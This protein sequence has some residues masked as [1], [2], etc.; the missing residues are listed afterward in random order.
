MLTPERP[1]LR[2][3]GGK[4]RL[5]PWIISHMPAHRIYVE[6]FG[7]GASVLLRKN[8]VFSEIYNDLDGEIVNVFRVMRTRS[9]ELKD[10][11]LLTPWARSE[12]ELSFEPTDDPLESA[13]RVI[14][15]SFM[16]F[17]SDSVTGQ[18]QSGFRRQSHNSGRA[19]EKDWINYLDA[20]DSFVWRLRGVV[21]ENQ[22]AFEVMPIH[23]SSET[24]YFVDPPYVHSTRG[25]SNSYRHEYSE[26]DHEKLCSLLR[27]L[28]GM[29][30]L[31]G[32]EN[33]IYDKLGWAAIK[34]EAFADQAQ[35]RTEVLWLNPAAVQ[36]QAQ[37]SLFAEVTR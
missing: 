37:Q 9:W 33:P 32:Y 6:P 2:Y 4:W 11:L 31:C 23:D 12:Y 19:P 18:R 27:E 29:V 36:A 1:V 24:L 7:G 14:V 26:A 25:T 34:R 20:L 21:L 3:F 5:A 17:A 15:R 28:K 30:L 16:G 13:R 22:D 35:P 8:P 10:Q